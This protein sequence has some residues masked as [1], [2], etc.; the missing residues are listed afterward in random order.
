MYTYTLTWYQISELLVGLF[1][2]HLSHQS[3][4]N[5]LPPLWT[6]LCSERCHCALPPWGPISELLADLFISPVTRQ[7]WNARL[8]SLQ[9]LLRSERCHCALP[10]WGEISLPAAAATVLNA[11]PLQTLPLRFTTMNVMLPPLRTLLHSERCWWLS[12]LGQDDYALMLVVSTPPDTFTI[13]GPNLASRC[14]A[15]NAAPL[16]TLP[17]RFTTLNVT[18]PP[19][20]TLLRSES[21]HCALP[22]WGQISL[23]G[24]TAPK[25]ALLWTLPL[26]FTTLR[27]NLAFKCQ[28]CR[29]CRCRVRLPLQ[30]PAASSLSSLELYQ[31]SDAR[32]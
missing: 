30:L 6:L 27:P 4:N 25:A 11:A 5:R 28:T 10:P 15:L 19:H 12:R 9:T 31:E 23:P 17:L 24:A 22:P 29:V 2:S 7:S 14:P 16:R 32:S 26:R 20:Q 18:L 13:L 1:I 3:W 21:C 8:P